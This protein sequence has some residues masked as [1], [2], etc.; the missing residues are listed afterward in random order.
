MSSVTHVQANQLRAFGTGHLNVWLR[1]N[2]TAY[3]GV[4]AVELLQKEHFHVLFK[5]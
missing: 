1:H 5:I 4:E 2:A 3:W